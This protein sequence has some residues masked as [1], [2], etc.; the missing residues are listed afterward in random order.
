QEIA[1]LPGVR[2]AS[3]SSDSPPQSSNNNTLLYRQPVP[4]NEKLVMETMSVDWDFFEVYGVKPVAGRLFSRD[5]PTD[6]KNVPEDTSKQ[7]T[8]AILV[9]ET[10][11]KKLGYPSPEA[12]VGQVLYDP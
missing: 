7:A 1:A 12:A 11:V 3:L 4:D 6:R 5:F 9:N 2:G 10:F 8:Q